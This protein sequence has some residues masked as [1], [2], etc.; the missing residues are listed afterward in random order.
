MEKDRLKIV[1]VCA[2]TAVISAGAAA[3]VTYKLN[4]RE[5]EFGKK[6]ENLLT[7]YEEVTS[8]FYKEIS[9]EDYQQYMIKGCLMACDEQFCEYNTWN[10]IDEKRVNETS[11]VS[12]SGYSVDKNRFGEIEVTHVEKG[13]RAEEMGL[14]VGDIITEIDGESVVEAGYYNIIENLLGKDETTV[15]LKI[16]RG[17]EILNIDFVIN[18]PLEVSEKMFHSEMLENKIMYVKFLSFDEQLEKNIDNVFEKNDFD[19]MI[20]DLRG[21]SGGMTDVAMDVYD[22]FVGEGSEIKLSYTR[23]GKEVIR[24]STTDGNE[25][26]TD[27]IVLINEDTISSAELFAALFKAD[28]RARLVGANTYGKGI[29]QNETM[30]SDMTRFQYTVG[31]SYVN[32]MPNFDGKGVSPDYEVPMDSSLIGTEEDV[33]LQKAMEL[34]SE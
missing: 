10:D 29:F 1:T 28:S 4:E 3:L 15:N 6:N 17:E 31:Y 18:N 8:Q 34:L 25:L 32:D 24:S 11:A 9:N 2:L 26:D 30:L 19:R 14:L 16:R 27:I 13:S 33:Q 23:S 22:K 5:I 20:I 7:V 21:N 12:R